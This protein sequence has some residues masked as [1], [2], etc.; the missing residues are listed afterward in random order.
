MSD[1]LSLRQCDFTHALAFLILKIEDLG[2]RCKIQEL[3]RTLETQKEY[4]AKGVSKTMDSRHLDRLAADIVLFKEGVLVEDEKYRPLGEYW[5]TLGGRW[6]GRF[7]LEKESKE[8]QA[9]KL[10]WDAPHF[11][12]RKV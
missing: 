2:Y 7:G 1:P 10:G 8:V 11:E 12:F 4:M 5:E 3:N 9:A 6:G